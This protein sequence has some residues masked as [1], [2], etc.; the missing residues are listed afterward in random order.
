MWVWKYLREPL[1][2]IK[3]IA[4]GLKMRILTNMNQIENSRFI[5]AN[6]YAKTK[7]GVFFYL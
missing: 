4:S 2:Y 3:L 1:D 5:S 6:L 7:L